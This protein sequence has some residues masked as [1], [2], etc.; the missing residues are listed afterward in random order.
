MEK[1]KV[2][3]PFGTHGPNISEGILWSEVNVFLGRERW[4]KGGAGRGAEDGE[5]RAGV[6]RSG[7]YRLSHLQLAEGGG[8]SG[9][10]FRNVASGRYRRLCLALAIQM[11]RRNGRWRLGKARQE[12]QREEHS[13]HSLWLRDF[14]SR[15]KNGG[16]VCVCVCGGWLLILEGYLWKQ[17]KEAGIELVG[18]GMFLSSYVRR[19]YEPVC[20]QLSG[21]SYWG[22]V[23]V[24]IHSYYICGL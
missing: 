9:Q 1:N 7:L 6:G 12:E 8:G 19:M 24:E 4:A 14:L 2:F 11:G 21:K 10:G 22:S 3:Y 18:T 15:V 17:V 20:T 23:K 16:W 13:L 5:A